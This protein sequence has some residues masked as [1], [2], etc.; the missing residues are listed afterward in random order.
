MDSVRETVR[1][2]K[3]FCGKR[4]TCD[5]LKKY[6]VIAKKIPEGKGEPKAPTTILQK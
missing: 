6:H 3:N 4:K 2:T 5:S 1:Q